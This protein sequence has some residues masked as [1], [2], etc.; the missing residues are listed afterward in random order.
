MKINQTI[1]ICSSLVLQGVA[2]IKEKQ[3]AEVA[4]GND[5]GCVDGKSDGDDDGF[6]DGKAEG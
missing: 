3:P 2:R 6:V 1:Y 4:E 5:E